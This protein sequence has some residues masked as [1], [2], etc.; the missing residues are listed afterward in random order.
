MDSDKINTDKTNKDKGDKFKRGD[1]NEISYFLSIEKYNRVE[2]AR[3]VP[4]AR[5]KNAFE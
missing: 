4:F 3:E 2:V 1:T 5:N